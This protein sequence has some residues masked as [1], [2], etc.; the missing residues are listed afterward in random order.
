MAEA[1]FACLPFNQHLHNVHLYLRYRDDL[2]VVYS[3]GGPGRSAVDFIIKIKSKASGTYLVKC[4]EI[5]PAVPFLDLFVY[6]SDTFLSTG[7]LSY[8]PYIKCTEQK[9]PLSHLSFHSPHVHCAWPVAEAARLYRRSSTWSAFILARECFILKLH[10]IFMH[11][12]VI[13][14]VKEWA[15]RVA[16]SQVRPK[17]QTWI[18]L[19]YSPVIRGLP[20]ELQKLR[21][22]WANANFDLPIAVG[23]KQGHNIALSQY[24]VE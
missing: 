9:V 2:F 24:M 21:L 1:D 7:K 17:N 3:R 19:P 14:R 18:V 12:V 23:H 5:A 15:P 22:R 8:R 10:A 16:K 13:Q 4:E 20:A 6:K 11:P